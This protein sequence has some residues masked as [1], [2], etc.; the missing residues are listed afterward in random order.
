MYVPNLMST[1]NNITMNEEAKLWLFHK[2]FDRFPESAEEFTKFCNPEPQPI[3]IC[4]GCQSNAAS[5]GIDLCPTCESS[6]N[7]DA[8]YD[9]DF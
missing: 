2:M 9:P 5:L 3:R 1:M 8:Y 7:L 4:V 6:L